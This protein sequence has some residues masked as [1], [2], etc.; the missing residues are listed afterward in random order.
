MLRQLADAPADLRFEVAYPNA[1]ET[2]SALLGDLREDPER[3]L[4]PQDAKREPKSFTL[5]AA[6]AMGQKRGKG[7][8]S[9]VRETRAQTFDFYRELVQ[10]LKPWQARAPKLREEPA[11][12]VEPTPQPDPPPFTA[13]ERDAGEAVDPWA[14]SRGDGAS[15]A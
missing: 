15:A 7:E 4:H 2:T 3:V 8:G 10:N 13:D 14:S 5:T 6:R 12:E 11:E 1:R 9:F